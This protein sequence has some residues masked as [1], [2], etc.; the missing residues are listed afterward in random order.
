MAR[1]VLSG[2]AD[3]DVAHILADLGGRAGA[4]VAGRYEAAFDNVFRRLER[5]P[6][7][8]APR[9]KLGLTTRLCVVTPYLVI[10]DHAPSSDLV[11]I[12]RILHGRRDM[13]LLELG[14]R[15]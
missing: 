10:Y 15:S 11:T 4:G 1:V 7:I 12:L 6:S 2:P 13:S 3:V 14:G 9:T 8:G 5:F